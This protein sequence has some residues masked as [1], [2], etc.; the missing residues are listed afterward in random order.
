M[1]VQNQKAGWMLVR[2]KEGTRGPSSTLRK[3]MGKRRAGAIAS[4]W[5]I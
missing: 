1:K 3:G 5:P 4:P 2:S